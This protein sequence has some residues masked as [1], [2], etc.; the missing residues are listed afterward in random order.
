M[1]DETT[2]RYG[3]CRFCGAEGVSMVHYESS[4]PLWPYVTDWSVCE[5]DDCAEKSDA[6]VDK[7]DTEGEEAL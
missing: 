7:L 3:S 5:A 1:V 2:W 4:D 6:L